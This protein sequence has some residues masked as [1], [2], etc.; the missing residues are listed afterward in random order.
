MQVFG[1]LI[2]LPEDERSIPLPWHVRA[3]LGLQ[4]ETHVYVALVA[5][6]PT[7]RD[8]SV[9]LG[10]I[11]ERPPDLVV[12]VLDPRSWG[13]TAPI[14]VRNIDQPGRFRDVLQVL[15]T[16][17]ANPSKDVNIA[18]AEAATVIRSNE[19]EKDV[20]APNDRVHRR[21]FDIRL[22][23]EN[24]AQGADSTMQAAIDTIVGKLREKDSGWDVSGQSLKMP[25][26]M[27]H[28]LGR[29]PV[30]AGVVHLKQSWSKAVE[31]AIRSNPQLDLADF[32]LR[33]AA[34]TADTESRYIRLVFPRIGARRVEISHRNVPNALAQIADVLQQ[35]NCNILSLYLRSG[36][37]GASSATLV[38]I[39]EPNNTEVELT[40][41]S[42]W[43]ALNKDITIDV[44]VREAIDFEKRLFPKLGRKRLLRHLRVEKIQD[45]EADERREL[46]EFT[47][48]VLQAPGLGKWIHRRDDAR[49]KAFDSRASGPRV[50]RNAA[51]YAYVSTGAPPGQLDII[52]DYVREFLSLQKLVLLDGDIDESRPVNWPDHLALLGAAN[53][54]VFVVRPRADQPAGASR[55][56]LPLRDE[57]MF[58]LMEERPAL[59]L[60]DW[61]MFGGG[62]AP[63]SASTKTRV[64]GLQWPEPGRIKDDMDRARHASDA[65]QL[66]QIARDVAARNWS[67]PG[68]IDR[69]IFGWLR[70]NG[71]VS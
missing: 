56:L 1:D 28:D 2:R 27:I 71:L 40:E 62:I 49:Q 23:C 22:I 44:R 13:S 17:N 9:P 6:V 42:L 54:G 55:S 4:S 63:L 64:A 25:G 18:L 58:Q 50:W 16:H 29:F 70:E 68:G 65:E 35:H 15:E 41:H 45:F 8:S 19:V 66:A 31:A 21:V 38:A 52:D 32:D 53:V 57:A 11:D 33:S 59:L 30:E 37:S 47:A 34:I 5:P 10:N 48:D 69:R 24:V 3:P 43:N 14:H 61:S 20:P 67:E 36:G 60:I 26:H 46:L 12:T 51:V 39:C 7:Q